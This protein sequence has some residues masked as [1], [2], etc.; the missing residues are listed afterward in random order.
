LHTIRDREYRRA[1]VRVLSQNA[2]NPAGQHG[3]DVGHHG[4]GIANMHKRLVRCCATSHYPDLS[5]QAP[6][7]QL[8]R[9][10]RVA[11]RS[12]S[13]S[14]EAQDFADALQAHASLYMSCLPLYLSG[15]PLVRVQEDA[16]IFHDLCTQE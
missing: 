14:S 13:R 6:L 12:A 11:G 7:E 4:G 3:V 8:H 16:H 5:F 15:R 2:E 9:I 1:G 10:V